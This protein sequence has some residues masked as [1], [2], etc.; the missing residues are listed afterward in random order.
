MGFL[1]ENH[2]PGG[3]E[4]ETVVRSQTDLAACFQSMGLPAEEA[5]AVATRVWNEELS[6]SERYELWERRGIGESRRDWKVR[7]G[8]RMSFWSW[9]RGRRKEP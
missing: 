1:Q 5:R 9:Q 7:T 2:K 6:A 4:V 3:R 8:R